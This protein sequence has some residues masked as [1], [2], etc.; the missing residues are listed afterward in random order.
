MLDAYFPFIYLN[1]LR[2]CAYLRWHSFNIGRLLILFWILIAGQDMLPLK[3]WV[4]SGHYKFQVWTW[5]S[6]SDIL[7]LKEEVFKKLFSFPF[8]EVLKDSSFLI[9]K[10]IVAFFSRLCQRA[11]RPGVRLCP[12]SWVQMESFRKT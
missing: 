10:R 11:V 2:V 1:F 8:L 12:T 5:A 6:L 7:T 9:L 3:I 4:L